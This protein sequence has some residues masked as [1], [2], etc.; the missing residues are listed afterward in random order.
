MIEIE[1]LLV[2]IAKQKKQ[3]HMIKDS[4]FSICFEDYIYLCIIVCVDLCERLIN[5]NYMI[6]GSY[7][8]F[9]VRSHQFENFTE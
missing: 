1:N 4:T 6:W 7:Y 9:I 3:Q 5:I 2:L 8:H